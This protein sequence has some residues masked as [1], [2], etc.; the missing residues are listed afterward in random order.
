[1]HIV[2]LVTFNARIHERHPVEDPKLS[3]W[4]SCDA[5]ISCLSEGEY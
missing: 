5:K 2:L 1:M 4:A 3:N